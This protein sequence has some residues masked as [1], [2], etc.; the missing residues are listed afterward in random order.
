MRWPGR[1]PDGESAEEQAEHERSRAQIEAGGLPVAAER[2]LHALAAGGVGEADTA[3]AGRRFT[4][5]LSVNE[6]TLLRRLGIQPLTQVMGSSIFQHGWQALPRDTWYGYSRGRQGMFG[7]LSRGN[8]GYGGDGRAWSRELDYISDAYNGARARALAR[9][10]A[11]AE[12]AGADAVV[13][14]RVQRTGREFAGGDSVEFT[15]VGTAV[16]LPRELRPP[17]VV[18]SDLSG[19][20]YVQLAAAGC[21]PV[22]V[23]AVSTVVYVAS[24]YQQSWVLAS[25]NSFFSMAGRA[26]QELP[27]FSQ[28]FY[29]A[30]ELALGHLSGQA[31]ALGAHGIV[32]VELEQSIRAR[33]YDDA[34]ENQHHDMIV[35]IH[36]LGTAITD[37]HPPLKQRALQAVVALR[38]DVLPATS[39][40]PPV[41]H[42]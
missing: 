24:S 36:L 17:H 14:V 25:G 32:G 38:P 7:G 13:G 9:L 6:F 27:D 5:D 18:I 30:R 31:D 21:R 11:E 37:G 12:L 3:G 4:S 39:R 40:R 19:Q 2:R 26:N 22:G 35:F 8:W 42:N 1:R 41:P 15:A 10:H 20:E 23:V 16:R 33:E 29:D 28:G 34:A